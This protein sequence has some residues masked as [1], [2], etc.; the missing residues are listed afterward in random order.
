VHVGW[1]G[2]LGHLGLDPGK[3]V[4]LDELLHHAVIDSGKIAYVILGVGEL[5]WVERAARPIREGL[6]LGKSHACV[7]L[8]Q[9][10]VAHLLA[11][12]QKRGSDLRVEDRS[13]GH[14]HAVENDLE[15]LSAGVE[16]LSDPLVCKDVRQGREVLD[17]D[18]VDGTNLCGRTNL[19]EA[20]L[21]I[22]GPLAEELRVHGNDG[23]VAN[24][25]AEGTQFIACGYVHST[26]PA[27][28]C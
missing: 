2:R 13:A 4:P 8:N 26:L 12:A 14:T 18:G 27:Q 23:L 15:V 6:C 21:G 16:D 25:L 9:R 17:Q 20:E 7:D 22:V 10:S 1:V 24:S 5:L 19:H 28:R 3:A 11:H